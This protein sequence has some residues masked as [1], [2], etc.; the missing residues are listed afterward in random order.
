MKTAL[1]FALA[2]FTVAYLGV[3]FV[4]ISIGDYVGG[5]FGS[6]YEKFSP[7]TLFAIVAVATI[8]FG[9]LLA[10]VARPIKRLMAL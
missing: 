8:A 1:F 6:V 9:L 7:P 3:W 5:L 2:I 4:S 10:L